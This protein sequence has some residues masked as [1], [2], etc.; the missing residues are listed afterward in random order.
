MGQAASSAVV[1]AKEDQNDSNP[2]VAWWCKLIARGLATLGA[3]IAIFTGI[4]ALVTLTPL[5]LV[6]GIWQVL[7]GCMVLMFEC[8]YCCLFFSL[9]KKVSAFADKR[10]YWQ[11]ALIYVLTALV[12]ICMCFG[13]STMFGSGCVFAAGVFYG[14]MALGKKA[15]RQEMLTASNMDVEKDGGL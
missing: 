13:A 2:E 7:L 4:W 12:P 14:L 10:T 11:K 1:A 3:I 9:V 5:C 15:D 6:A 8:P